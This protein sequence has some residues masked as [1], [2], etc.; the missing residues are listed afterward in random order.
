MEYR[1][2]QQII[3]DYF[4]EEYNPDDYIFCNPQGNV[5]D[6]RT[7]EDL[8]KRCLKEAD[9]ENTNFHALRHTFATRALE[10]EWI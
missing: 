1:K 4:G 9:I 6:P 7:Y 3:K 5:Y 8:F 10:R 2:K